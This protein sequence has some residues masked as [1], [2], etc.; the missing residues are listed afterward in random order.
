MFFNHSYRIGL[1]TSIYP[2]FNLFENV[3]I[4]SSF[5]KDNFAHYKNLGDS[6]FM[7]WKM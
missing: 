6:S 3:F 4:S 5:L 7:T 2:V 1:G